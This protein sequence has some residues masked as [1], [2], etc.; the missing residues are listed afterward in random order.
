MRVSK[1]DPEL[2]VMPE[3]KVMVV[4]A[5]AIGTI[6]L[7][8]LTLATTASAESVLRKQTTAVEAPDQVLFCI[9][10][11]EQPS[12]TNALSR[13]QASH[14]QRSQANVVRAAGWA[15]LPGKTTPDKLLAAKCSSELRK[16]AEE[17]RFPGAVQ[18]ADFAESPSAVHQM[19]KRD[20][21]R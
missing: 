8:H 12:E 1:S 5:T 7:L 6:V 11:A 16:L 18:S 17:W 10:K 2:R 13:F 4:I 3:A 14:S 15:T 9:E 20:S 19:W 21:A